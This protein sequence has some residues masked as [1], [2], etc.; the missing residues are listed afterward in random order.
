MNTDVMHRV[1][2]KRD[3]TYMMECN[4]KSSDESINFAEKQ[5]TLEFITNLQRYQVFF[6]SFV[7]STTDD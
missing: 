7:D 6:D 3:L 5:R 1:V 4:G 2:V